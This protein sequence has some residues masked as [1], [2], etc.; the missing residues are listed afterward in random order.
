MNTLADY[1][2]VTVATIMFLF[3]LVA[4]VAGVSASTLASTG[5]NRELAENDGQQLAPVLEHDTGDVPQ[6]Y[7]TRRP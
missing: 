6:G 1:S 7:D 5:L 3:V 4:L 2:L